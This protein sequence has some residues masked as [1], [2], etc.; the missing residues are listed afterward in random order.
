MHFRTSRVLARPRTGRRSRRYLLLIPL[1]IV[2]S[3]AATGLA[4]P[5]SK[6]KS[7]LDARTTTLEKA[8]ASTGFAK[9]VHT[10]IATNMVGFSWN[11]AHRGTVEFRT[12]SNG[13]WSEWSAIDGDPS[14]G[15]D[16]KSHEHRNQTSAGPV[17]VGDGVHDVQV[18]VKDG[19][20]PG[21]RFHAINSQSQSG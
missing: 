11:G 14:E 21:L 3:L 18:R 10:D 20:M 9:S 4:L 12:L 17:W 1:T 6:V 2:L 15:P 16:V 8:V 19:S 13:T 7:L 5:A